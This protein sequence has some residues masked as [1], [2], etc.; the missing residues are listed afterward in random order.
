MFGLF[1]NEELRTRRTCFILSKLLASPGAAKVMLESLPD[2]GGFGA[3]RILQIVSFADAVLNDSID[4]A[5]KVR[6]HRRIKVIVRENV[7]GSA[8]S[9]NLEGLVAVLDAHN[10]SPIVPEDIWHVYCAMREGA[11]CK[12]YAALG[13]LI[14]ASALGRKPEPSI[15]PLGELAWVRTLTLSTVAAALYPPES[16]LLNDQMF[17]WSD[18]YTRQH[19]RHHRASSLDTTANST[20][21]NT[22]TN[23]ALSWA[24][25]AT[26]LMG[27]TGWKL[28]ISVLSICLLALPFLAIMAQAHHAYAVVKGIPRLLLAY[29][30]T[31]CPIES[32][33]AIAVPV[34]LHSALDEASFAAR[35]RENFNRQGHPCLIVLLTDFE[36]SEDGKSSLEECEKLD[37]LA[38][39]MK[40]AFEDSP[41]GWLILHRERR[42]TQTQNSYIG[43][44][45]KRGKILQFCQLL[46]F[47]VDAFS[48][49]YN[50]EQ[51]TLCGVQWV[52][53][54][55]E[56]S[57]LLS[58]A[59]DA[60]LAAALHPLNQSPDSRRVKRIFAPAVATVPAAHRRWRFDWIY[61]MWAKR[62]PWF[63]T[64]GEVPFAGKGLF[65]ASELALSAAILPPE[66]ILSHDTLEG[67]L[68]G[69]SYCE[70]A[71]IVESLPTRY[72]SVISRLHRWVRGDA[73]NWIYGRDVIKRRFARIHSRTHKIHRLGQLMFPIGLLTCMNGIMGPVSRFYVAVLALL[74]IGPPV[75]ACFGRLVFRFVPSVRYLLSE[76]FGFFSACFN[77]FFRVITAAHWSAV[78]AHAVLTVL[79]RCVSGSRLLEW[80]TSGQSGAK[81]AMSYIGWASGC[82][83]GLGILLVDT[84]LLAKFLLAVWLLFP[85]FA[86]TIFA[87]KY[88]RASSEVNSDV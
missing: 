88:A 21:T 62:N 1:F 84:S 72:E 40:S 85:A 29:N 44:E 74:L 17:R 11:L 46:Y 45:R 19:I 48:K 37:H 5:P 47:G 14:L 83:A 4:F 10:L 27:I 77:H 78:I 42:F 43:W 30:P 61:C 80:K 38:D 49:K 28:G 32:S 2:P 7:M 66:R 50:L 81:G 68:L 53:V 64:F 67:Y 63:E 65:Q 9:R 55:D 12:F 79:V 26:L 16:A 58:G 3:A 86:A 39:A 34:L 76:A 87:D 71:R 36:D 56:D 51:A 15:L 20:A 52:L 70:K 33:V 41:Q 59:L 31:V 6:K 35:M 13:K 22:G 57:V 18:E 23:T 73:Q 82:I 69:T 24:T 8:R 60:L 25:L 75:T 54:A